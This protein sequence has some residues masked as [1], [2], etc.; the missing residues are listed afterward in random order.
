VRGG[1]RPAAPRRDLPVV[2]IALLVA[3]WVA[4]CGAATGSPGTP[5]SS[6]SPLA[7]TEATGAPSTDTGSA[8][9]SALASSDATGEQP[10]PTRWPGG[11][12]EAVMILGTADQQIKAA[13]ADL[14]AAVANEDVEAL[15][16]A[17]D[18]LAQL[19]DKLIPQIDRIS[20]YPATADAAR[21]YKAALPE[22][23]AAA[24]QVRDAIRAGDSATVTSGM[25][26]LSAATAKYGEARAALGPL[27][28]QAILMQR[29]LVK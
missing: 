1:Y 12:V 2:A 11:V 4:A 17:T 26:R 9:A 29:V 14:G 16:G 21:A 18:G 7:S 27:V 15:W 22:M 13:G 6:A 20:D 25:E 10:S 8:G 23:D 24:K 5:A 28:D 3:L 19:L